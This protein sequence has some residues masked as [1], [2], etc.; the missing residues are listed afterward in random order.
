MPW[1]R[2]LVGFYG[3]FLIV[4]GIVGGFGLAG[5]PASP[6]SLIMGLVA[7]IIALVFFALVPTKPRLAYIGT[8]VMALLNVINF[9]RNISKEFRVTFA[10]L[11]GVSLIVLIGLGVAHIMAQKKAKA[12]V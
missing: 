6:I 10:L 12:E 8:A 9:S 3:V 4:M 5:H 7:G 1:P 2:I 11:L